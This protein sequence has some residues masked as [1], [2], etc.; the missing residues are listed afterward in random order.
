MDLKL[1]K[2]PA[3]KDKRDI[4]FA[5]LLDTTVLPPLPKSFGH[6]AVVQPNKWGMLGNDQY[7][8]CVW[9]GAC[10][11]HML[12]TRESASVMDATFSTADA[13]SD[14]A[15]CTGFNPNDPNSDQGTDMRQAALYR[16][17]TGVI[18]THGRRHKI[19]AFAACSAG[20]M[21]DLDYAIYLFGAAGIGIEFP[22]SAMDQFNAGQVWDYVKGSPI[23]G[24]HYIA[25]VGKLA[26]GNYDI[27]T[28][29]QVHQATPKFLSHYMDEALAYISTEVFD[30]TKTPEGFNLTQLRADLAKIHA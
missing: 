23:E 22:A 5:S 1:G 16:Q 28:W 24:G 25:G 9:A 30:G 11:E 18:D 6:Y 2:K 13:L 29:G 15:A 17:K 7:G 19:A 20:S 10:H 4:K 14:Y 27:L 12:W 8:D 21:S 3:T 26:N